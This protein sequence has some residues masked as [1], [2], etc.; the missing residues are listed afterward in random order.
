M[1]SKIGAA[2]LS[3]QAVDSMDVADRDRIRLFHAPEA[4]RIGLIHIIRRVLNKVESFKNVIR[5]KGRFFE[6]NFQ[7]KMEDSERRNFFYKINVVRD[8]WSYNLMDCD[9][10]WM[11]S[12]S[13]C[14][15]AQCL[16]T[17][18]RFEYR[19]RIGRTIE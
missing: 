12:S 19:L 13:Y 17:R 11:A 16:F 15:I 3:V 2:A 18:P 7:W 1:I 8:L 9:R 14:R 10:I 6:E 4:L 5:N